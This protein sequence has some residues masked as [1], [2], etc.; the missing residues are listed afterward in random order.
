MRKWVRETAWPIFLN[1]CIKSFNQIIRN[2]A[3]RIFEKRSGS[4]KNRQK[5]R[6]L[7]IFGVFGKIS[8]K[9]LQR[10]FRF[11]AWSSCP[12]VGR[13]WRS[14][15]SQEKSGSF[16]NGPN[17]VKMMVLVLYRLFVPTYGIFSSSEMDIQASLI[18]LHKLNE[19]ECHFLADFAFWLQSI[20]EKRS[21]WGKIQCFLIFD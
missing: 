6:F 5:L 1:F 11:Y 16:K 8:R 21:K 12:I 9:R 3:K 20:C 19:K 14:Q 18:I 2:T 4:F 17:V 13:N 15:I 10:F 7:A